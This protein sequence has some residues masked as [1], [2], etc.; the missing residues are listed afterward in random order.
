MYP[1]NVIQSTSEFINKVLGNEFFT[2]NEITI[3]IDKGKEIAAKHINEYFLKQF[4]KGNNLKFESEEVCK[5]ILKLI[6]VDCFIEA[7]KQKG[8]VDSYE[9][10]NTPEMLFITNKGIKQLENYN[11]QT[12]SL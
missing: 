7:L 5:K 11:I 3:N 2:D 8:Y 6:I 12:G 1:Q 4:I 9:D 10:E